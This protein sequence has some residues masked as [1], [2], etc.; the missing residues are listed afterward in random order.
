MKK[1][2]VLFCILISN[3]IFAQT[4]V[5]DGAIILDGTQNSAHYTTNCFA[6]PFGT[7]HVSGQFGGFCDF[8]PGPNTTILNANNGY[9]CYVARYNNALELIWAK[10]LIGNG[11][12]T[13]LQSTKVLA[14]AAGNTIVAGFHNNTF[15]ADPGANVQTIAGFPF[16]YS[17]FIVSLNAVGNY[18]WSA[19]FGNVNN[20]CR[21]YDFVQTSN[22]HF[23][24]C[25]DFN[26]SIDFD[27][28]PNNQLRVS[29]GNT[30][31]SFVLELNADGSFVHVT[32]WD[33]LDVFKCID[34]DELDNIYV[35]GAYSGTTD[36]D[37]GPGTYILNSSFSS[38][39]GIVLSID[40]AN[41]FRWASNFID[42]GSITNSVVKDIAYSNSI[43]G[44]VGH[45]EN[46]IDIDPG[47]GINNLVSAGN[48]DNFYVG[49]ATNIGNLVWGG[50][51][52]SIQ[53]DDI[54][55]M[56]VDDNGDFWI[57]GMSQGTT[58]LDLDPN[59][60]A[61]YFFG[62]NAVPW[63]MRLSNSGNLEWSGF[64]GGAFLNGNYDNSITCNKGA[65]YWMG[66]VS[67]SMDLDPIGNTFP[68]T[69]TDY[70]SASVTKLCIPI[71]GTN[72]YSLCPG[73]SIYAMGAWQTQAGVYNDVYLRANGCDSIITTVVYEANL[74]INLGNDTTFCNGQLFLAINNAPAMNFLW[75]NGNP[76][77]YLFVDSSGTYAVTVS[78]TNGACSV[79]DT[80]NII[81]GLEVDAPIL[82]NTFCINAGN[83]ALPDGIPISGTW[84][85]SGIINNIFDPIIGGIGNHWFYYSYTDTA[86]CSGIDSINVVVD[87]CVGTENNKLNKLNVHP[88][89]A[90]DKL[91]IAGYKKGMNV[92]L[93]DIYGRQLPVELDD[94]GNL[95][96][97]GMN[98]G[99]YF[100]EIKSPEK[101]ASQFKFLK[102]E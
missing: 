51:T 18:N 59:D 48:Y 63:V 70:Y 40:T 87:L 39:T 44:V 72:E 53:V 13:G 9:P 14:D 46:S 86:N 57:N 97:V 32:T 73:D 96:L 2:L 4:L 38:L 24:F 26:D 31:G 61:T 75:N 71:N 82:P 42:V 15:D 20:H 8:D 67:N 76:T 102:I 77:S 69:S 28:G 43:L 34:K 62:A 50:R 88:N 37:P 74:N 12:S 92:L 91:T 81:Y 1:Y 94:F 95:S 98:T 35:G 29:G 93:Y 27:P 54:R 80:I 33:N 6:D 22:G 101:H 49:L 66:N 16:V 60:N 78:S 21:I 36:F 83:Y 100:I 23:H 64:Q 30:S 56:S 41:N 7:L 17:A 11:D 99:I 90:K 89:P 45:F 19:Q 47:L 3:L 5:F 55:S 58:D 68:T 10:L 25:G 85:G 84:S 52:G 65:I 79:S